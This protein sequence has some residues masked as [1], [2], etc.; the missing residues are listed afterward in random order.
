MKMAPR[1]AMIWL[2]PGKQLL[3]DTGLFPTFKTKFLTKYEVPKRQFGS[4][5]IEGPVAT[6][7]KRVRVRALVNCFVI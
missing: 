1:R 3:W 5:R 2:L 4:I 7:F 6:L